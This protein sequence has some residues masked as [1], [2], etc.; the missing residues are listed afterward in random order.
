M[1]KTGSKTVILIFM[2][3]FPWI[4]GFSVSAQDSGSTPVVQDK[5]KSLDE[6][7]RDI[8]SRMT[9]EEKIYLTVGDGKFLPAP[10]IVEKVYDVLYLNFYF[11]ELTS[12]GM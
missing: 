7:A 1:R 4:G 11:K 5:S 3:L 12:W 8:I 10:L 9:T 6:R 2:L